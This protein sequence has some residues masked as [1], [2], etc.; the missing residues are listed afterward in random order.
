MFGVLCFSLGV[1]MSLSVEG[2]GH[3]PRR[4]AVTH[5][6]IAKTWFLTTMFRNCGKSHETESWEADDLSY[7]N[8]DS[9]QATNSSDC[10]K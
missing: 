4:C 9:N 2:A 3:K 5:G 6:H 7:S 1:R 8:S 10:R